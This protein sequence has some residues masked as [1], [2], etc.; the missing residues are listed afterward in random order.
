MSYAI[1]STM[2]LAVG[3]QRLPVYGYMRFDCQIELV[4][5]SSNHLLV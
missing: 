1:G 2:H 5:V 3:K 4:H